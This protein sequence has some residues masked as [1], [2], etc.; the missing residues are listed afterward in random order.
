M[1]I[2]SFLPGLYLSAIGEC[3]LRFLNNLGK[4]KISFICSVLGVSMHYFTSY[5]FV[6]WMGFGFSGLGVSLFCAYL[7]MLICML[8]YEY[9]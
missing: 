8:I 9:F 6:I 2:Y 7:T 5:F 3:Q 4:T 1:Y